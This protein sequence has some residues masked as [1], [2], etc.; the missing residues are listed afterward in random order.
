MWLHAESVLACQEEAVEE[1]RR[2]REQMR[3]GEEPEVPGL[4]EELLAMAE[5]L[6]KLL[7]CEGG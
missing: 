5:Y 4:K 7:L 6:G 3:R 1:A 2:L